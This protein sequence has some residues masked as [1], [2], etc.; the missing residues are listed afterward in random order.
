MA[1]SKEAKR[2]AQEKWLNN[3]D[4][5]VQDERRA[6]DRIRKAKSRQLERQRRENPINQPLPSSQ[7]QS[8]GTNCGYGFGEGASRELSEHQ[9]SG[10]AEPIQAAEKRMPTSAGTRREAQHGPHDP[11]AEGGLAHKLVSIRRKYHDW[12]Y[13]D[14]WGSELRWQRAFHDELRAVEGLGGEETRLTLACLFDHC[15]Q[16]RRLIR[17]LKGASSIPANVCCDAE[18]VNDL[19]LQTMDLYTRILSETKFIEVKLLVEEES[20]VE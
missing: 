13:A 2:R 14:D 4:P 16:G 12:S 7:S 19:F 1:G 5:N 18:A 3:P 10:I 8:G 6:K 17:E 11:V 15:V 20:Y 9:P